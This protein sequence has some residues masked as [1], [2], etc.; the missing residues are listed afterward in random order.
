MNTLRALGIMA[1]LA[2][3]FVLWYYYPTAMVV[4]SAVVC[5]WL[6]YRLCREA[7]GT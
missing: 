4:M 1:L 2:P 7:W 6:I 3:V 5:Y